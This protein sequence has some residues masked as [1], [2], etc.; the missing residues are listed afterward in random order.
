[1]D[2]VAVY[3]GDRLSPVDWARR[4]EEE[5]WHGVAM[6]DHVVTGKGGAWHPFAALGAMAVSTTA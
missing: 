1:M 6:A 3:S 5:E 4:R 2:F